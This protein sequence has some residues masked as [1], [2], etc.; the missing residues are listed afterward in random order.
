M[1][2]RE[3][4]NSKESRNQL[5]KDL[6]QRKEKY[7]SENSQYRQ[8]EGMYH[9]HI[10]GKYIGDFI[11]GAND[12]LITT[13]A[14]VA[15]SVGASLSP[16]VIIILGFANIFADGISMGASNYLGARSEQDY[17]KS[18]RKKEEWEVEHLRDIEVDEIREIFEKKGFRGGDLERAVAIVTADKKVWV[19]MMMREE[20]DIIEDPKDDPKKHGMMTFAA[21]VVVGVLPLSPYLLPVSNNFMASIL[22]G[23]IAL[24]VIG[25]SRTFVTAVNFIR[26]G[27]EMLLIG[28]SAAGAAYI[29]GYLIEKMVR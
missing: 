13:F 3:I 10:V 28:S 8:W 25:G 23:L 9:K 15:G 16:S 1:E 7:I 29:V 5:L 18:Q 27:L 26:G 2:K 24:F 12:G 11:Y 20:L 21:F 4:L 14:I 22:V 17:A 6:A 19:D